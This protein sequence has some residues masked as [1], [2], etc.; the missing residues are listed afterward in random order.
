MELYELKKGD[1]FQVDIRDESGLRDHAV[2]IFDHLDGMYSY[3]HIEGSDAITHFKQWTP[4][5]KYQVMTTDLEKKIETLS[6]QIHRLYCEQYEKDHDKPYWTTGNY[7]KLEERVKEYDRNIARFIFEREAELIK[8]FDDKI[9][10]L[11]D[12]KDTDGLYRL[13]SAHALISW[14]QAFRSTK[15][16]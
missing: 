4:V 11:P 5:I 12:Q 16:V 7:S 10:S 14:L 1:R 3:I 2:Y 9:M 13:V 8:K 6:E 15:D